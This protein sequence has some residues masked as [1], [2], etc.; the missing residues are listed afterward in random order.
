VGKVLVTGAAS[1]IGEE[2]ARYLKDKGYLV[3]GADMSESDGVEKLDVTKEDS[4][5][6]IFDRHGPFK[7][8][9]NCAGIRTRSMIVDTSVGEFEKHLNVNVTGTWLGI[10][11]MFRQGNSDEPRSIV[12]IASVNSVIAVASQAHYVA[13]KGAIASLTKAA[14]LEGSEIGI[15][16]NAI[17][18]GPIR[19]PMTKERL[20]DPEQVQWLEGRVPM[21][22]FG[23][24]VEIATTVEYLITE[25]SSYV[26]GTVIFVDG[27]WTANG[28]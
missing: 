11:E 17:A 4:W 27:G 25:A 20:A 1:G 6:E 2:T 26:T 23:E 9:V 8:L 24:P 18:P 5:Y 13:S 12:N 22:R 7:S 21:G 14:A 28:A 15:R 10:R 3:T 19:T 16:V